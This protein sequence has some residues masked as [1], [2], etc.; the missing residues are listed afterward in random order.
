LQR[1]NVSKELME[2]IINDKCEN[3]IVTDDNKSESFLIFRVVRQGTVLFS[4]LLNIVM[5]EIVSNGRTREW[6]TKNYG[7]CRQHSY[8]ET[9]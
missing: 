9:E 8:M 4:V 3:S 1:A 6:I 2:R 5:G 7:R